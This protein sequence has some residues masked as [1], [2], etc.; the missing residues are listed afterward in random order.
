MRN[1]DQTRTYEGALY[2]VGFIASI[3]FANWLLTHWGTVRF[4]GGP[5]LI[6]VWPG[7][8]TSSGGTIYAPSGVIAIGLSFTLRDL[9]QRRLGVVM[10]LIAIMIGAVLSATLDPTLALASGVAF[11][12]AESLDLFVYT[13]LQRRH[14]IGAVVAS[15]VVG[16]V[17]DSIVFLSIAFSSLSLLEGQVI[18]KAWM[19]LVAVPVVYG[20]RVWDRRRG[21]LPHGVEPA[22][23]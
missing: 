10:A 22:L 21:V 23:S 8:L 15:N 12:L 4:P 1:G 7:E 13:P 5:W 3:W 2:F 6:P 14:L 16:M 9:V 18:G 17:V 11:L 20:I 19:T